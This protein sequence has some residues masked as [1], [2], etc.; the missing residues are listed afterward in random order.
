MACGSQEIMSQRRVVVVFI[1]G[2]YQ[3]G[4]VVKSSTAL[5]PSAK[6]DGNG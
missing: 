4:A 2:W 6:A 3:N 1:S 5:Y